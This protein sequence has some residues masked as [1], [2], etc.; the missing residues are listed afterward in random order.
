MKAETCR[1]P[2]CTKLNFH[3]GKHSNECTNA[4]RK[5]KA[6]CE[7]G[8]N[9]APKT[10]GFYSTSKRGH[11]RMVIETL[12]HCKAGKILYLDAPDAEF[13]SELIESGVD[14][15]RLCPVNYNRA[16]CDEIQRKCT[17]VTCIYGDIC[18][19]A[20]E[21]KTHEYAVAWFDMCGRTLDVKTL[22]H[23]AE[24]KFW[25]LSCRQIVCAYQEMALVAELN[26]CGEKIDQRCI[27]CGLSGQATNMVFVASKHA[28]QVN[29]VEDKEE[30][31]ITPGTVVKMPL[32]Y[33]KDSFFVDEYGYQVFD[34]KYL[35]GAV[36]SL[37]SNSSTHVRLTFNAKPGSHAS[38]ILCSMQYSRAQI[39]PY[40]MD[41]SKTALHE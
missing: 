40:I 34:G 10:R 19:I 5:R 12:L 26:R 1:T 8:P 13:T 25:T 27:Y 31:S 39:L 38:S 17:G 3:A 4:T 24:F 21:A 7:V 14:P 32:S 37:C 36:H 29:M 20:S 35:I 6:Q 9:V 15:N 23:C 18:E 22:T 41:F 2:G 28:R 30:D 33:W 11:R 16:A